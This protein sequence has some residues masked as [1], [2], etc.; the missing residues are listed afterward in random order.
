MVTRSIEKSIF[1][2]KGDE[3]KGGLQRYGEASLEGLCLNSD[4]AS[5]GERRMLKAVKIQSV[6]RFG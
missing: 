4:S 5:F 2:G 6:E 3:K 1:P